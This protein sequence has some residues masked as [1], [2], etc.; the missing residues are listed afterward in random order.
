MP[1]SQAHI[2]VSR[3]ALIE[4][5]RNNLRVGLLTGLIGGLILGFLFSAATLTLNPELLG[6][7]R[8]VLV[9]V[10]G[11]QV[12]Y[13]A[14]CLALGLLG[15]LGKTLIFSRTGRKLSDTKTAA[16]I[17][18]AVFFLITGFYGF[19]WC[20]W[21]RIGGLDP[22]TGPAM[23]DLP[24]LVTIAAVAALLARLMTY[25]F[26]LLIVHFKK[27]ERRQPGDLRKAFF[28]LVYMAGAFGVFVVFLRLTAEPVV[29]G[30]GLTQEEV[31]APQ[32]QVLL[33]AI[34]G[35]GLSDLQAL[36]AQDLFPWP[37]VYDGGAAQAVAVPR[38]TV[39][40]VTW[41]VV[42]TGQGLESHRI[43]D[44]QAQ[45]MR[46]LSRPFT[47]SPNQVGLFQLFQDVLPWF[48]L[49][50][51]VP[52]RSYMRGAKALWN[53]ATDAEL[54]TVL[55]NWWITWPAER[56]QGRV[57]SD[58][59]YV[60]LSGQA[61]DD[62]DR[63]TYP[64][65][66]LTELRPFV[67]ARPA[68]L[69]D[70]EFAALQ[71]CLATFR[72]LGLPEDIVQSDLFYALSARELLHRETPDLWMLHLPGPD[73]LRRVFARHPAAQRS[74]ADFDA[75]LHAYWRVLAPVLSACASVA[76]P[77]AYKVCLA[78]PGYAYPAE[79]QEDGWLGVLGPGGPSPQGSSPQP[80][81][82]RTGEPLALTDIAP[83]ILWL[84]GLPASREMDGAPQPG[85]ITAHGD[86][87]PEIRWIDGYGRPA[88]GEPPRAS[89][90][91]DKEMLERFRSL[92]YIDG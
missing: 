23:A 32:G 49:T 51:P 62:V 91:L 34:D 17:T 16:F 77:P 61:R 45:V 52:M 88:A 44:Y 86:S 7:A 84:L 82:A 14:F 19:V 36:R 2:H 87:L 59:A 55:T 27:P 80:D 85:L 22:E 46:G 41:T 78:L 64:S 63:E 50:T 68:G 69:D 76:T 11:L 57:V 53:I 75:A 35:M 40:P 26:Y 8:D 92:G 31:H 18:G 30:P 3:D 25:A 37:S 71:T 70:A 38:H 5:A 74:A 89:G 33:L 73:V 67:E 1:P 12:V 72:R 83:T 43:V 65:S 54:E 58:L 66:L 21:H 60:R 39:P 4:E 42:A 10:I 48:R 9:L 29:A 56:I 81:P 79:R 13:V 24:M 28:I 47:V 6:S 20:R 15:A 90:P